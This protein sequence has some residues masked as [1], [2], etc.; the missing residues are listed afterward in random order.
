MRVSCVRLT[1]VTVAVQDCVGYTRQPYKS[2]E[3]LV[4]CH[5]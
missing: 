1:V 4:Q 5:W 2:E 3:H